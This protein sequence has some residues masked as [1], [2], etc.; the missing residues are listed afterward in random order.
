[1]THLYTLHL[2]IA[3]LFK[4]L[5]TKTRATET[6]SVAEASADAVHN[7]AI[8]VRQSLQRNW[9]SDFFTPNVETGTRN[10][11]MTALD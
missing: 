10:H 2:E 8:A 5:F 7:A 6:A 4:L 1:M 11:Y 9:P 3:R